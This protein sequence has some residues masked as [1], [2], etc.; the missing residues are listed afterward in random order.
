MLNTH[1]TAGI[2]LLDPNKENVLVCHATNSSWKLWG[3]PKGL[4]DESDIDYIATAL[5]EF[6]EET[7]IVLSR[8][9]LV[10]LGQS[11]YKIGNKTLVAYWA[12]SKG[13]IDISELKCSNMVIDTEKA[14]FPEV[15][16]YKWLNI[17]KDINSLYYPQRLLI[18]KLLTAID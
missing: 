1:T 10:Y 4:W 14:P 8:E 15:D 17:K 2:F 16:K 7:S 18:P 9:D 12:I 3:I 11:Q 13:K 6:Q 5:R